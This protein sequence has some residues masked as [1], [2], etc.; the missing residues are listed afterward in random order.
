MNRAFETLQINLLCDEYEG[1]ITV[2]KVA[3]ESL[4]DVMGAVT[5]ILTVDLFETRISDNVIVHKMMVV[6][7][8]TRTRVTLSNPTLSALLRNRHSN[9]PRATS[10]N[11]G[12]VLICSSYGP[13]ERTPLYAVI[14]NPRSL[15]NDNSI[16]Q[17]PYEDCQNFAC[18]S[19]SS[20]VT[21][22][23]GRVLRMGGGTDRTYPGDSA[24]FN[25]TTRAWTLIEGAPR[26]AAGA[27]SVVLLDGRVLVTGG[28]TQ[29]LVTSACWLY[30]PTTGTF[31]A[32]RNM[33]SRKELHAG[34]LLATGEVF[35]C[36]GASDYSGSRT[37]EKYDP[38]SG[39]WQTLK[40]MPRDLRSHHCTLKADGTVFILSGAGNNHIYIPDTDTHLSVVNPRWESIALFVDITLS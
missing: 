17:L 27:F 13:D 11:D 1:R 16:I 31:T 26:M 2:P 12:R 9:G 8:S 29:G 39:Y 6:D 15:E 14:F 7:T 38:V 21:L 33:A 18:R 20:L 37:C 35:I 23:D 3:L 10:L 36:G 4:A 40:D 19:F 25:P 32:A 34:C 22:H 5:K 28:R 24:L 30:N